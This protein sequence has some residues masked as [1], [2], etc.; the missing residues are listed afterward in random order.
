LDGPSP[1]AGGAREAA[2]KRRRKMEKKEKKY[3]QPEFL[4][5]EESLQFWVSKL[6]CLRK[7]FERK[8]KI[9]SSF[10][11]TDS[12]SKF[13]GQICEASKRFSPTYIRI[14]PIDKKDDFRIEIGS[15]DAPNAIKN[16]LIAHGKN[17]F[18]V[19][20]EIQEQIMV[21]SS[22]ACKIR[23][24]ILYPEFTEMERKLESLSFI[25]EEMVNEINSLKTQL[26]E[27]EKEIGELKEKTR[28]LGN[29]I[30][31]WFAE[32]KKIS[33]ILNKSKAF[34]KSKTIA[35]AR[36]QTEKIANEIHL[37]IKTWSI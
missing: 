9:F 4:S 34:F 6:T 16:F 14:Y 7:D 12:H 5:E 3:Q 11:S 26:A 15:L 25:S 22:E 24:N 13:A 33:S 27:K 36:E 2:R 30:F 20:K 37:R 10:Q 1:P 18:K 21:L 17:W 35:E 28:H 29:D 32:L 31:G 19:A 23:R 8:I